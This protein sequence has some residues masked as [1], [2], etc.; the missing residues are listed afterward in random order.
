VFVQER[1]RAGLADEVRD[2][3][4]RAVDV[5]VEHDAGG[6]PRERRDARSTARTAHE[7]FAD[8]L[9]A[10]GH[11][12]DERL[13]ALFDELHDADTDVTVGAG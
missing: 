2:L 3:L 9:D 6:G 12:R 4:P 10:S 13:L 7:L 1:A 8:Y 11:A 5:R